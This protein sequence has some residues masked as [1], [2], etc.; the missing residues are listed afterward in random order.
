MH[1]H[2]SSCAGNSCL[3]QTTPS[4]ATPLQKPCVGHCRFRR[5]SR[6]LRETGTAAGARELTVGRAICYA[7]ATPDIWNLVGHARDKTA[8]RRTPD[9]R[10]AVPGS[11]RNVFDTGRYRRG[12]RYA[13]ATI[14]R[15]DIIIGDTPSDKP[16]PVKHL[17]LPKHILLLLLR[18]P[19]W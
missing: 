1:I 3:P 11:P 14:W 7:V 12:V 10:L 4:P 16:V 18:S 17:L 19:R 15:F 13:R 6:P 8:S 5:R 2:V 9:G